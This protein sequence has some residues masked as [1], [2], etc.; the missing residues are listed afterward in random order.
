MNVTRVAATTNMADEGR[1]VM[2]L[3]TIRGSMVMREGISIYY[4]GIDR[5]YIFIHINSSY[6][7]VPT[8]GRLVERACPHLIP[9]MF[10][11]RPRD[12][13]F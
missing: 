1:S 11:G 7:L 9:R 13:Y 4:S 6:I 5:T 3:S 2:C 8:S 12:E 10:D